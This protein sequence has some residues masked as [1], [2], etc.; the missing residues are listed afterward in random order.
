AWLARGAR[1]SVGATRHA[2]R[3]LASHGVLR[4]IQR[5][6]AGHVMEIRLP[7][8]IRAAL[9][10]KL[11]AYR[12]G[13]APSDANLEE[14]DFLRSRDLRDSIHA[15][16][17]GH[18]FYCLRRITSSVRCLD[19]VVPQTRLGADSYRNLV[20]SCL[21]CNSQKGAHSAGDFLRSLYRDRRLT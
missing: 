5:S 13:Q 21:E 19:H 8:E 15:R 12:P 16:E 4:L 6:K 14:L 10:A 9:P 2:L 3:R 7:A 1:L 11:V 20:S 18:C 17:G